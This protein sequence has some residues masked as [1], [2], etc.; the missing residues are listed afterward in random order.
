MARENELRRMREDDFTLFASGLALQ[1]R[2]EAEQICELLRL[3]RLADR[4]P[5]HVPCLYR[6]VDVIEIS[7]CYHCGGRGQRLEGVRLRDIRPVF[8]RLAA[9]EVTCPRWLCQLL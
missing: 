9:I 2:Q 6:S 5:A 3:E 8:D 1:H 4:D 7:R